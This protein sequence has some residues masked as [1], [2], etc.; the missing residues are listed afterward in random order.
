MDIRGPLSVTSAGNQYVTLMTDRY[1]KLT[2]AL[3]TSKT[4]ARHIASML[5]DNW[6]HLYEMP[7]Y[8]LT[9]NGTQFICKF[10]EFLI[11]IFGNETTNDNSVSHP[12]MLAK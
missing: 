5:M 3:P 12:D 9:E 6:I 1:S 8:V 10:F 11:A 4:S 2:T 7:D